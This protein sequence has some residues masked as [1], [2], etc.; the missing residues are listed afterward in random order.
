MRLGE[1]FIKLNGAR[2]L[3]LSDNEPSMCSRDFW[4]KYRTAPEWECEVERIDLIPHGDV[5]TVLITLKKG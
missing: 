3:S 1:L 5:V 2:R 4:G